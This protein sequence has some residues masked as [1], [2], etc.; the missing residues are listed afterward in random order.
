VFAVSAVLL[1]LMVTSAVDAQ[2]FP[3]RRADGISSQLN[4]DIS[5]LPDKSAISR[6]DRARA[7][8][9]L[10]AAERNIVQ[11]RTRNQ[12]VVIANANAAREQLVESARLD[13]TNAEVYT[14]LSDLAQIT[15]PYDYGDAEKLARFALAIDSDNQGA[16]RTLS[17]ILVVRSELSSALF[18]EQVALEAIVYLKKITELNPRNAEAWA[19]LSELYSRLDMSDERLKALQG[20]VGSA[21]PTDG[22]FYESVIGQGADLSPESAS[23][24]LAEAYLDNGLVREALER[25]NAVINNDPDDGDAL[26][27]LQ[28]ALE[29]ADSAS[30]RDAIVIL[31]QALFVNPENISLAVALSRVLFRIGRIDDGSKV[32]DRLIKES[33]SGSERYLQLRIFQADLLSEVGEYARATALLMQLL[34]KDPGGIAKDYESLESLV[35]REV[36][37]KLLVVEKAAGKFDAAERHVGAYRWVFPPTDSFPEEERVRILMER[38]RLRDASRELVTVRKRFPGKDFSLLETSLL[39]RQGKANEAISALGAAEDAK[40]WQERRSEFM[41]RMN[42][43]SLLIDSGA[44][45]RSVSYAENASEFAQTDE[46]RLIAKLVLGSAH[47]RAG[48]L[49]K[50]IGFVEEALALSPGNP[51][52]MNNLGFMLLEAGRDIDRAMDL[53]RRAVRVDPRNSAYLDSLGLAYLLKG[54]PDM[55]IEKLRR[56]LALNPVSIAILEHLGDTYDVKRERVKALE[57]WRRALAIAWD[58]LVQSRLKM[59]M[60][61]STR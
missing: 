21:N 49:E 58:P 57:F 32:L 15:A 30:A 39:A 26:A 45:E 4:L 11:M 7:L 41:T 34:G 23:I 53:I 35:R 14:A 1:T 6:E 3:F 56:A 33:Q 16:N 22:R 55:A 36:F 25:L 19:L 38:G 17:R 61:K 13:P 42:V 31:E 18:N 5:K 20:W 46:D 37:R 54:D 10:A 44:R 24:V 60:N 48:N 8:A 59:K 43:V 12:S 51:M 9:L 40:P 2:N 47:R 50:A 29:I 52:A 28:E 27:L